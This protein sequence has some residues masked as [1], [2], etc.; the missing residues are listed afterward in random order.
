M[1]DNIDYRATQHHIPPL[2]CIGS[3]MQNQTLCRTVC[4]GRDSGSRLHNSSFVPLPNSDAPGEVYVRRNPILPPDITAA[5]INPGFTSRTC[6]RPEEP[7]LSQRC[8]II[9][10]FLPEFACTSMI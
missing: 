5:G 6:E 8:R 7:R 2:S 3:V 9:R 10:R 1:L 4:G